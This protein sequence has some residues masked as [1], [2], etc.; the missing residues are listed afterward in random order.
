MDGHISFDQSLRLRSLILGM[1]PVQRVH[2]VIDD[3]PLDRH[4][5][6]FVDRRRDECFVV[7]GNLDIWMAPLLERLGCRGFASEASV[8]G[9][10]LRVDTVL[11]KRDAVRSLRAEGFDRVI[12]VGDGANDVPMFDA[13]DV[14]IAFAGVHTPA[15]VATLSADFIVHE[16]RE[17]CQLLEGL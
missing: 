5:A 10:R 16:G 11:D 3:V 17:L 12:A 15:R 4:L 6:G 2:D 9:G 1:V 8:V 14:A 13:A 7:T